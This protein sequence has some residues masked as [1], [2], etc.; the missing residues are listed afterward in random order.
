MTDLYEEQKASAG[1]LATI[2]FLLTAA[3]LFITGPGIGAIFSLH[4][5]GFIVIGMFAAAI[6]VGIP[7]YLVQRAISKI[8]VKALMDPFS[9]RSVSIVK[10]VGVVLMLIQIAVTALLTS[11]A[12]DY[13]M[14]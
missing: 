9:D 4:G 8:L 12:F 7:L 1:G 13:V 2:V 10:G 14:R 11:L 3:V 5:I 6:A